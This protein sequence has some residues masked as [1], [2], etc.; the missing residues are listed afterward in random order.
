M[1]F[2][3]HQ[4]WKQDGREYAHR[5]DFT[6][7]DEARRAHKAASDFMWSKPGYTREAITDLTWQDEQR[8]APIQQGTTRQWRIDVT[9]EPGQ[10]PCPPDVK[11][12]LAKAIR[13][14]NV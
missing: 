4:V 14:N 1:K 2:Y 3:F 5:F 8:S 7:V 12:Q 9:A 6:K 13:G 10:S 11:Q